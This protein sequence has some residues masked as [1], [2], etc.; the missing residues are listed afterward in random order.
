M[1]D[2]DVHLDTLDLSILSEMELDGRQPISDLARKLGISRTYARKRFQRLL[3]RNICR[4][5]AFT[6]PLALGY[7]TL[8][9]T[10][11]QASPGE[12]HAVADRLRAFP[13]VNLVI[14]AAGWQDIFVLTMFANPADLSS[15]LARGLGSI[16]GIKSTETMVVIEWRVSLSYLSPRQWRSILFSYPP[17]SRSIQD[18]RQEQDSAFVQ[19]IGQDSD[20]SIDQLDLM[21]LREIEQD[22]RQ[23]VSHLAKKLGISRY[24]ASPRLQRL[25]NKRIT[26]VVAFPSPLAL[27]YHIFALIGVKVSLKEIDKALDKFEA[28]PNVEWLARVAGRYDV[29]LWAMFHDAIDLSRFLGRELGIIPGVVSSEAMIGLELKK[30]SFG[31]LASSYVGLR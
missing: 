1:G 8:A 20:L 23:P 21:I 24:D 3:D 18:N 13:N 2:I 16:P 27:G 4:I 22:A 10:G 17:S 30:M 25:L 14:I 15:F 6:H 12:L 31:R 7:H 28:L 26:S 9:L 29:V 11:I 19:Q 5:A